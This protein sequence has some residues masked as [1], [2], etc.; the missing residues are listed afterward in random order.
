VLI[1]TTDQNRNEFGDNPL[2]QKLADEF[3][4][5]EVLGITESPTITTVEEDQEAMDQF[6]KTIKRLPDGRYEMV[7]RGEKM[8]KYRFLL[9]ML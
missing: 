4:D 9:I 8:P 5:L 2:G 1:F 7:G 6:N 3:W